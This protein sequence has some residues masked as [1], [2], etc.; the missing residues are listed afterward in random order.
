MQRPNGTA[1]FPEEPDD[2]YVLD[3][4]NTFDVNE[5]PPQVIPDEKSLDSFG[6]QERHFARKALQ[7][8]NLR[9]FRNQFRVMP[10]RAYNHQHVLAVCQVI[11]ALAERDLLETSMIAELKACDG[12]GPNGRQGALQEL[13]RKYFRDL[14][15]KRCTELRKRA[16]R[17]ES[18]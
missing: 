8:H 9:R 13:V 1:P 3:W 6:V 2:D 7:D 4:I 12:A 17:D 11:S 16:K 10:H 15:K 5:D 14:S 18:T